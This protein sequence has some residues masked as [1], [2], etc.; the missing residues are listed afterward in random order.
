MAPAGAGYGSLYV[1]TSR[2][3]LHALNACLGLVV[4]RFGL[5]HAGT[6][7]ITGLIVAFLLRDLVSPIGLL[8]GHLAGMRKAGLVLL[9]EFSLCHLLG[10]PGLLHADILGVALHRVA[11]CLRHLVVS[12]DLFLGKVVFVV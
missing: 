12:L 10:A 4:V 9:L 5:V 8:F 2:S 6:L 7:S 11:L 1:Q 3:A